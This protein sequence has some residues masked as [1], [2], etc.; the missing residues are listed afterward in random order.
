MLRLMLLAG[1]FIAAAPAVAQDMPPPAE[2][3]AAQPPQAE[4]AATADFDRLVQT[5]FPRRD[6]DGNG[7]LDEAEFSAWIGELLARRP[8]RDGDTDRSAWIASAFP[9]ADADQSGGVDQAEM[10]AFLSQPQ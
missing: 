8:A 2:L 9:R 7:A 4:P 5:E 6:A 10:T 3:P 1:T